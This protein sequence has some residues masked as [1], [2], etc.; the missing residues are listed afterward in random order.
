LEIHRTGRDV[1]KFDIAALMFELFQVDLL[2]TRGR[3]GAANIE[4]F[5]VFVKHIPSPNASNGMQSERAVVVH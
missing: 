4:E 3:L 5:R 1:N 2:Q